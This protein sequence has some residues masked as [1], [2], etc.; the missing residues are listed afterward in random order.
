[1]IGAG[2]SDL[3]AYVAAAHHGRIRVVVRSMPGERVAGRR[4]RVRGIDDG[5]ALLACSLGAGVE[6]P[7][8]TV[9]LEA[10]KLGASR[11]RRRFV[12]GPGVATARRVG[13]V[14]AGVSGDA[15]ASSGR[16]RERTRRGRGHGMNVIRLEGC[17]LEPLGSYLKALSVLRLVSE[18][19]DMRREDGGSRGASIW[20]RSWMRT[21]WWRSFWSVMRRRRFSRRGTA[22][23][24]SI[25]RIARSGSMRLPGATDERFAVYREAI[26]L[27]RKIPGVGERE[28]RFG[29]GRRPAAAANSTGVPEPAA[30]RKRGVVGRRG[31]NLR[32]G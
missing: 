17:R 25:R 5:D 29:S 16:D 13:A 9:W 21:A 6:R 26:E 23:A 12:D 2:E 11:K 31:G 8:T 4:R 19:A 27:A 28:G 3:A 32:R 1:M 15:A 20:R 30:G 7:E 14:P 10:A 24:D 22:E 18:Q